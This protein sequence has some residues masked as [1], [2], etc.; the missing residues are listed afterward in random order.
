M[1][2]TYL[3]KQEKL[4]SDLVSW[5]YGDMKV[6]HISQSMMADEL[7]IKQPSFNNKLR[8]GNFTFKDLTVIFRVLKP[9][10]KT[11]T[12]LMGVDEWITKG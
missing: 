6:K 10:T 7:G 12:R 11:I 2:K 5:I 4:N 1:P 3:T 8:N 9:D